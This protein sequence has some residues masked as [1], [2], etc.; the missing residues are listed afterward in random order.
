MKKTALL[1]YVLLCSL[2]AYSQWTWQNPLPQGN[3][4]AAFFFTASDTGY[5]VGNN[6]ALMKT[7]DGGISWKVYP[8]SI[9]VDYYSVFFTDANTGYI[10][11]S[12]NYYGLIL[13][14]TDA[15]ASWDTCYKG[16]QTDSYLSS[17]Y[18]P[19]H[20]IGYAI[21]GSDGLLKTTDAGTTWTVLGTGFGQIVYF[22]S[23]DTGYILSPFR[24]A[25]KTT[26]GGTTWDTLPIPPTNL[27]FNSIY[28]TDANTGYLS[29]DLTLLKTTDAGA[30]WV[31]DTTGMH[32]SFSS[33]GDF[34]IFFTSHDT[35]Y[36]CNSSGDLFKTV[37]SGN[38]W[39]HLS[40]IP[41][42]SNEIS[43]IFFTESKTAYALGYA[44]EVLKSVNGGL[45]WT[46][47]TSGN[48]IWGLYSLYFV[49]SLTGYAGGSLGLFMKTSNGGK[50]WENASILEGPDMYSMYFTSK[51]DG[52]VVGDYGSIAKTI[53]AGRTWT[54]ITS[55][56][57]LPLNSVIF[58][59][60]VTGY[61]AGG[62]DYL[63]GHG[64]ILKT[65]DAGLTWSPTFFNCK[66]SSIHFPS[67]MV[68]YAVGMDSAGYYGIVIKTI[69][70][71]LTWKKV[72]IGGSEYKSVFFTSNDTGFV[73]GEYYVRKTRDGGVHWSGA[74][75]PV[76]NTFTSIFFS[77]PR[78]GYVVDERGNIFK[79]TDAGESWVNDSTI[80]GNDLLS[81]F[82]PDT[83]TAFA[84]GGRATILRSG[85][86]I[87]P[88]ITLDVSPSNR[89]V[90]P[91]AGNTYFMV[92]S[93]LDWSVTNEFAWCNVTPSGTGN[94]TIFVAY[95]E[96]TLTKPR[97][98]TIL[99]FIWEQP[100]ITKKVT[101][102]QGGVNSVENIRNNAF[103]M[104]PNPATD[105]ITII[106]AQNSY[107]EYALSIYSITGEFVNCYQV[108]NQNQMQ[109]EVRNLEKGI[110]LV[111]LQTDSGIEVQ[112]LVIQ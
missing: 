58:T 12:N 22:T 79:T 67:A 107:K 46:S 7:T 31:D 108:R 68:G 59:D 16:T 94:D 19:T 43:S 39:F 98:D 5:A 64:I 26:N 85:H 8:P 106:D 13:K 101:V 96:N 70:G 32:G 78:K 2:F 36:V 56:T 103:Q 90:G 100:M 49:D 18:F 41:S 25:F 50:H 47:L 44:S 42:S 29:N 71:G 92:S 11:G 52:V 97:V 34:S 40:H 72:N 61:I 80:T 54:K 87:G 21:G 109:I 28:F 102:T 55:G 60:S 53:N 111:K 73:A 77:S 35:G 69:D 81:V 3:G 110:Y 37:D 45:S 14:T 24:Y 66:L 1:C 51:T 63:A 91:D 84:V 4:L 20:N 33:I 62:D 27:D 104:Y 89:N 65:T 88:L 83:N 93:Y 74:T 82:C 95:S 105:K 15:G 75:P 86:P 10:A 23:P 17:I 99:V 76:Y 48:N 57:T 6:G 30:S 38:T 112:K 9:S